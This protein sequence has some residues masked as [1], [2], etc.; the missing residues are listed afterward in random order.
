MTFPTAQDQT[1]YNQSGFLPRIVLGSRTLPTNEVCGVHRIV[2][3]EGTA[4][5]LTFEV[6]PQSGVLDLNEYEGASVTYDVLK[7]GIWYR[8]FTGR[9]DVPRISTLRTRIVLECTD[10]RE[11]QIN[12]QLFSFKSN[13]GHYSSA[14]QG[15][16]ASVAEEVDSRLRTVPYSLDFNGNGVFTYT[17][18]A[19]KASPD[20]TLT[21]SDVYYEEPRVILSS[22]DKVTNQINLSFQYRYPRLHHREVSYVWNAPY[23]IADFLKSGHTQTSRAL[24]EAAITAAG[25]PLR[26]TVGYTDSLPDGSYN[27]NGTTVVWSNTRTNY[28]TVQATKTNPVPGQAP[29]ALTQ[30][31]SDG[32]V[33]PVMTAIPESTQDLSKT[34]CWGAAW[35]A[36]TRWAQTITEDYTLTI[37]APQ[38]IS[39]YTTIALSRSI[40]IDT[41]YNTDVWE[42]YKAYTNEFPGQTTTSYFIDQEPNV[43]D[44]QQASLVG[45]SQAKTEIL[46]AHRDTRVTFTRQGWPQ[47]DLI[48]TVSLTTT[49]ITCKGKVQQIE[50]I[51]DVEEREFITNVELAISRAPGSQADSPVTAPTRPSDNPTVTQPAIA[52]QSHFGVDPSSAA[53]AKWTG[54]IGN[55][56]ITE[57]TGGTVGGKR[58]LDTRRTT[59]PVSFVV[60]APA[61][62]AEFRD[63]RVLSA[64]QTYNVSI[65]NDTLTVT[66]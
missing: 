57:Y 63:E 13:I 39:K 50:H 10:D 52:L 46:S 22:R 55:K 8:V 43:A 12:S 49:P 17:A 48:H 61:I 38:S 9:V 3:R 51:L 28:T 34:F 2:R 36:T 60:D 26:G 7:G 1:N 37:K 29:I 65:P 11:L 23:T 56:Y 45:I 6:Q 30:T 44:F 66:I 33:I 40:G 15:D 24:V 41:N 64:S 58:V 53:A 5:T 14:L 35:R 47:I 25:W 42:N 16:P 27:V 62:Q 4:S 20:F 21:D 32:T 54:M 59:Y 31:L 18:W 19:A